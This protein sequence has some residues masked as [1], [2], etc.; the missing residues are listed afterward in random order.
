MSDR[1]VVP[2]EQLSPD[3]LQGVI[4]EFI[5]R[6]GTDYGLEEISL[7][8]K[9]QQVREELRKGRAQII[10]DPHSE[11]CTIL[12]REEMRELDASAD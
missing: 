7:A 10:F 3:A 12:S 5:T 2:A 8:E 9:V 11:T 6:E 4:E 1:I